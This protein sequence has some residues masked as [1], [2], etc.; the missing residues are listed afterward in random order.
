MHG[1]SLHLLCLL[2]VVG[3][4][5]PQSVEE[6][7]DD[8]TVETEDEEPA[9]KVPYAS[10]IVPRDAYFTEHF[11]DPAAFEKRWVHSKA[12]K[13]GTDEEIAKY[14]GEWAIEPLQQYAL[15]GDRGMVLKS[16]AKHAAISSRLSKPFHFISKPL[17]VQYE[18]NLQNGQECGGAYLK[19][20]SDS[21][22]LDPAAFR[23]KTP[24][25]IMF[26][27]DKCGND[28]K[29]H[30][31]FRHRN[32][33]TGEYEEKHAKRATSQIDTAF[34]DKATHLYRLVVRPDNSFEI[35]M[36]DKVV[37]SGSLLEDMTPPVNPPKMID[38][39][40]DS[41]PASWDER[42]KVPDPD[43]TKP[44]DWDEEA[45]AKI[46]DQDAVRPDGWLEDEPEMVPDPDAEKP[47]DWDTE[48]D[49]EWEAP[50][51]SNPSCADAPGCG[52]WS[53]PTID[54][55]AYKGKWRAPMIDNPA[56]KGKWAPRRIENPHY[57]E[58]TE[59]FKMTS[60]GAVGVELWSMSD[61]IYFDNVLITDS[62][63]DAQQFM[64]ETF[65][66][67]SK[68]RYSKEAGLFDRF[69]KYSNERPWLYA[70]YVIAIGLPL[71][72]VLFFC[73]SGSAKTDT[74]A[75]RKKTDEPEDDDQATGDGEPMAEGEEEEEEQAE[76]EEE[77]A[78]EEPKA[79]GDA[80]NESEETEE[81]KGSGDEAPATGGEG[82]APPASPRRRR[83]RRE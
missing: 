56:Y 76:G 13:D 40:S 41:K 4:V 38:D 74:A 46:V 59:P 44:D 2:L 53:A 17:V 21:P 79:A 66:L 28:H 50:L 39:P 36:D 34:S 19:L 23:D 48:M 81:Q 80:A 68:K 35:Y 54:N 12:K 72:L 16:R 52:P 67:K 65:H 63:V 73:C 26:G 22:D 6:V 33:V 51:I 42:E 31:I 70:V 37:N 24:Y 25:T 5:W 60:I 62:L 3:S 20:L 32:P 7:D 10:P 55:P 27:P 9:Q 83:P 1:L 14:D 43:A 47:A 75:M 57:F 11:D 78:R 71:V 29:L 45:P 49:G 18:V 15:E 82:D 8:V 69:L 64:E 61:N 58:D 77:E 30:F